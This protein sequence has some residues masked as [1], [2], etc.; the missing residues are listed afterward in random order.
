MLKLEVIAEKNICRVRV[1]ADFLDASLQS[2]QVYVGVELRQVFLV[3]GLGIELKHT[4]V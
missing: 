1:L 4:H 3:V 2:V